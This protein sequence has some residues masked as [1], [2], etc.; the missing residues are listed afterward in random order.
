MIKLY[1]YKH[2]WPKE[3][4]FR[5]RLVD[6]STRTNIENNMSDIELSENEY[7]LAPEKPILSEGQALGWNGSHWEII[8]LTD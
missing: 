8:E 3:L 1:S 5:I 2:D 7:V 4:P 6:G